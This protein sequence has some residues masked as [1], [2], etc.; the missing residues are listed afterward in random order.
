MSDSSSIEY[1]DDFHSEGEEGENQ[2]NSP[3]HYGPFAP[4]IAVSV[5]KSSPQNKRGKARAFKS[6][7]VVKHVFEQLVQTIILKVRR[8]ERGNLY[9]NIGEI[10]YNLDPAMT[11]VSPSSLIAFLGSL[12]IPV[13]DGDVKVFFE[14]VSRSGRVSATVSEIARVICKFEASPDSVKLTHSPAIALVKRKISR[15]A[16]TLRARHMTEQNRARKIAQSDKKWEKF[17][18]RMR[19]RQKNSKVSPQKRAA[20]E[21][22]DDI[23]GQLKRKRMLETGKTTFDLEATFRDIDESGDGSLNKVELATAMS[24]LGLPLDDKDLDDVLLVIDPDGS[25]EVDIGEFA[26][27]YYNRRKLIHGGIH[28][29]GGGS[30]HYHAEQAKIREAKMAKTRAHLQ[31]QET[32]KRER[33]DRKW[34]RLEQR[35]K[36]KEREEQS[37]VKMAQAHARF[38]VFLV[39]VATKQPSF[40]NIVREFEKQESETSE[41]AMPIHYFFSTIEKLISEKLG[42]D[43]KKAIKFVLDP[44]GEGVVHTEEFFWVLNRQ[45]QTQDGKQSAKKSKK[46]VGTVKSEKIISRDNANIPYASS[47]PMSEEYAVS[48]T[49]NVPAKLEA[50]MEYPPEID[51]ETVRVYVMVVGASNLDIRKKYPSPDTFVEVELGGYQGV[52]PTV[53]R[54]PNPAYCH[55]FTFP[56]VKNSSSAVLSLKL[57]LDKGKMENFVL[58]TF[59]SP[60]R[61]FDNNLCNDVWLPMVDSRALKQK[62]RKNTSASNPMIHLCIRVVHSVVHIDDIRESPKNFINADWSSKSGQT[63]QKAIALLH[64]STILIVP[65][66]AAGHDTPVFHPVLGSMPLWNTSVSSNVRENH[67][68]HLELASTDGELFILEPASILE[69]SEGWMKAVLR[70]RHHIKSRLCLPNKKHMVSMD[71]I[72]GV[73]TRFQ[74]AYEHFRLGEDACPNTLFVRCTLAVSKTRCPGW[75]LLTDTSL[76]FWG[77]VGITA[78]NVVIPL[79]DLMMVDVHNI[80]FVRALHVYTNAGLWRFTGFPSP[81]II[82]Q[83]IM[84]RMFVLMENTIGRS[85]L[86]DRRKSGLTF[87]GISHAPFLTLDEGNPKNK[88]RTTPRRPKLKNKAGRKT[89]RSRNTTALRK[90][91]RPAKQFAA[92]SREADARSMVASLNEISA[93]DFSIVRVLGKSIG[94]NKGFVEEIIHKVTGTRK[95]MKFIPMHKAVTEEMAREIGV[96]EHIMHPFILSSQALFELQSSIAILSNFIPREMRTLV[97]QHSLT[98]KEASFYIAEVLSAV[99]H[100]HSLKV[101]HRGIEIDNVRI[102]TDG[103]VKIVDVRYCK[104]MAEE[105][106]YTLAGTTRYMSPNRISGSGH[107]LESDLWSLGIFLFELLTKKTPF[108]GLSELQ[109]YK[110]IVSCSYTIP[111]SFSD[112]VADFI[113]RLLLPQYFPV[114]NDGL[115]LCTAEQAM[116]HVYL[117]DIDWDKVCEMNDVVPFVPVGSETQWKKNEAFYEW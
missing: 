58:A 45:Y 18:E 32:E 107:G 114:E 39:T 9:E 109:M 42:N 10:F 102:K 113:S 66:L 62:K 19:H 53:W 35:K 17:D 75:L 29:S 51:I 100:L 95:C 108:D 74:R 14:V 81:S 4:R 80:S 38:D 78:Q 110:N 59:Q 68:E 37:Q 47:Q 116:D 72:G 6:S 79:L 23:M 50:G 33:I 34:K 97:L 27:T 44:Q 90:S 48:P 93:D 86:Y 83:R 64:E 41:R 105:K 31:R 103:R 111:E 73:D 91:P 87:P 30:K 101:V 85:Q 2:P 46:R 70:S 99:H 67:Y 88:N 84:E 115:H 22:F 1:D 77:D 54:E 106:T 49:N 57:R 55:H 5:N 43:T 11:E 71:T 3:T 16:N 8:R 28:S 13:H 26:W 76:Y 60:L 56:V 63:G 65:P 98:E 69:K 117:D 15:E 21:K 61:H 96:L 94:K 40:E 52:T 112:T 104:F 82:K 24:R 89:P 25:G 7:F 12:N 20:I 92:L 36:R